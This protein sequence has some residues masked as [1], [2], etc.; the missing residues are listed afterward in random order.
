MPAESVFKNIKIFKKMPAARLVNIMNMGFGRALGARCKL[1]HVPGHWDSEDKE[2]KATARLMIG[3]VDT[4]NTQFLSRIK[5]RDGTQASA[6]C[7]MCHR[8]HPH[9]PRF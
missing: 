7:G 6:N 8:G 4:L 5:H 2:E 1:C 9:P 3:M